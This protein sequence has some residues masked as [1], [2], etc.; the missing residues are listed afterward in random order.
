MLSEEKES[1]VKC[2]EANAIGEKSRLVMRLQSPAIKN[3]VLRQ[4]VRK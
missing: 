3:T 2:A 1:H 4:T